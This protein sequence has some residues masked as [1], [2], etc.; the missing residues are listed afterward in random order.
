MY[1]QHRTRWGSSPAV[2]PRLRV[3]PDVAWKTQDP[4]GGE[5]E[6]LDVSGLSAVGRP[7]VHVG[8]AVGRRE[9]AA[10]RLGIESDRLD[11]H[12]VR[13]E[14]RL[15]LLVTLGC[16]RQLVALVEH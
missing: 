3:R 6:A 2:A 4:A 12:P 15:G 13:L 16:M 11:R 5:P 8:V 10:V 1:S 7:E 14:A 9:D